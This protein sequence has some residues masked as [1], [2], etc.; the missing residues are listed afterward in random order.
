[1]RTRLRWLVVAVLV[2]VLAAG[3][4]LLRGGFAAR[5]RAE[6]TSQAIVDALP[7]VAQRI[8]DFHR[9]KIDNGRKVWEVTAREAQYLESEELV[10]VDQP[11]LQ[12]FLRDGRTVGLRGANGKIFLKERELQRVEFAGDIEVELGEYALHTDAAQYEAE[13]GV[14]IAPGAVR[15]TG[16]DFEV[17]GQHMEV[18]VADQQMTLFA[19][20]QTTL[21]PRS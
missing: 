4:W 15:I 8:Q 20:V 13:G 2:L 19:S 1:M 21:W 17:L 16:K 11:V 12:V 9:V 6:Q 5:R 14:I 7:N 3:A 18:K 10:V